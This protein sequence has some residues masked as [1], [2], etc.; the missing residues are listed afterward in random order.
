MARNAINPYDVD[1]HVAELYDLYETGRDDV[2]LIRRLIGASGPLRVLE[3][4][5]GTGRIVLPLALDGHT[6]VGLDRAESMLRRARDRIEALPSDAAAR[7][8]LSQV[9]VTTAA[10][11][12]GFDLVVLGGNCLYELATPA[13]QEACIARAAGSLK[14]GG[15]VYLDNDHME[16]DLDAA[17]RGST[18]DMAFPSG[19]CADGT[20]VETRVTTVWFD[21]PQRRVRFYRRTT[22]TPPGGNLTEYVSIQEK[23]PPSTP[24]VRSWL[25]NHGFAIVHLFGDRE[26][27]PYGDDCSRAIFWAQKR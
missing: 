3:P 19:R 22:V 15:H 14:S 17:W 2:A 5:C 10:W 18:R 24:E 27:R 25:A 13:E 20:H 8:S 7:V 11:P 21:V 9:D 1:P 6:L 23:H 26:G 12:Q 4:F 16:G